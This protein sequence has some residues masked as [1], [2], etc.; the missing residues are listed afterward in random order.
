ML[1]LDR[2]CYSALG[3]THAHPS[4]CRGKGWGLMQRGLL[5]S[6]RPT[7]EKRML[8]TLPTPAMKGLCPMEQ[9]P[10]GVTAC[11]LADIS[12]AVGGSI[13]ETTGPSGRQKEVCSSSDHDAW[14][15]HLAHSVGFIQGSQKCIH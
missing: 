5:G 4:A 8:L 2:G 10:W 9:S 13:K 6:P 15:T 3:H 7:A 14:S 1:K 11:S 12:P